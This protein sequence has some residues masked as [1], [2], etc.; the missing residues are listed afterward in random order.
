[1]EHGKNADGRMA[2]VGN[3]MTMACVRGTKPTA[4]G[5]AHMRVHAGLLV[6]GPCVPIIAGNRGSPERPSA[7][8]GAGTGR[9]E[10][11]GQPGSPQC[12][13]R[14]PKEESWC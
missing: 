6:V 3:S 12:K 9:G 2:Q 4:H 1:M 8:S 5:G 7:V 14:G 10:V 11:A 13:V